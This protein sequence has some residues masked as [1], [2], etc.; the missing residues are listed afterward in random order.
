M[1]ECA[2]EEA[3]GLETGSYNL[4]WQR[5]ASGG[6]LGRVEAHLLAD[7]LGE[8]GRPRED[9]T[10]GGDG[11][12]QED[13]CECRTVGTED[14]HIEGVVAKVAPGEEQD[15]LPFLL[16]ERLEGLERS[17]PT[18]PVPPVPVEVRLDDSEVDIREGGELSK[19]R[20]RVHVSCSGRVRVNASVGIRVWS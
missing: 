19:V 1:H 8:I 11:G 18:R 3:A 5:G 6:E 14:G 9:F 7:V 4:L 10:V 13:I 15:A 17:L 16:Q 2:G 20:V 12:A